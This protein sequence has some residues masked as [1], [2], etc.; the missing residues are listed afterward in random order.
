MNKPKHLDNRT[1][2]NFLQPYLTCAELIDDHPRM[3]DVFSGA[4]A[5]KSAGDSSTRTLSRGT[6]FHVL[7]ACTD[8]TTAEVER[9]THGRYKPSTV[10]AYAGRARLA[11]LAIARYVERQPP[12][13]S[14]TPEWEMSAAEALAAL[15]T[16]TAASAAGHDPLSDKGPPSVRSN[17]RALL[18][19]LCCEPDRS[20]F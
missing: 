5:A 4:L 17:I 12:S 10:A 14:V 6:L 18:E 2:S 9:V 1:V 19:P 13:S 20:N 8:I 11:S 7:R 15:D 16:S 3:D